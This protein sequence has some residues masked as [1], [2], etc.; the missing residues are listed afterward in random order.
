MIC[1][2][3][4]QEEEERLPGLRSCHSIHLMKRNLQ[5]YHPS[6]ELDHLVVEQSLQV[7][8]DPGPDQGHSIYH[9]NLNMKNL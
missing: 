1:V 3:E 5:D 2:F 4:F 7:Y 6:S 9:H 8:E